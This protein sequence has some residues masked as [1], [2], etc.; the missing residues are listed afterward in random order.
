MY[1]LAWLFLIVILSGNALLSLNANVKL[2]IEVIM[3]RDG[4]AVDTAP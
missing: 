3:A 1:S 4:R 2:G